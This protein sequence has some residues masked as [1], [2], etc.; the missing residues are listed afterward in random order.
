VPGTYLTEGRT[1]KELSSKQQMT[2]FYFSFQPRLARLRETGEIHSAEYGA[3]VGPSEYLKVMGEI[4]SAID[5]WAADPPNVSDRRLRNLLT[6]K[7]LYSSESC[8]LNHQH[9]D[10]KTALK[11]KRLADLNP[12]EQAIIQW[13]ERGRK[14]KL[15]P[16][17]IHLALQSTLSQ[18]KAKLL[19]PLCAKPET[20]L[21]RQ[22][23]AH[24]K[25]IARQIQTPA[26]ATRND[27]VFGFRS[28]ALL[29][30]SVSTPRHQCKKVRGSPSLKSDSS[31]AGG[32]QPSISS[33]P[34]TIKKRSIKTSESAEL[35]SGSASSASRNRQRKYPLA[36]SAI[37]ASL[38]RSSLCITP[39]RQGKLSR[40]FEISVPSS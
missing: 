31:T 8:L 22:P 6:F 30:V 39:I 27:A 26:Q 36:R 10:K 23:S 4:Y 19:A 33:S 34:V 38:G 2:S 16:Q 20:A 13:L 21:T 24:Q 25:H 15:S 5:A 35:S 7:H 14:R 40:R 3:D 12:Q 11:S 29:L 9:Q 32:R 1:W 18:S 28:S 17:Q 37:T